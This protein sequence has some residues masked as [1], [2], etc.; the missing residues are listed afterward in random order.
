M[1]E[2]LNMYFIK[3]N[4]M[5]ISCGIFQI[6]KAQYDPRLRLKPINDLEMIQ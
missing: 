3:V 2:K 5:H 6:S 4:G 1:E